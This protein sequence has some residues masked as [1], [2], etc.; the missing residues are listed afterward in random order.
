MDAP[1]FPRT[2]RLLWIAAGA[3]TVM[4]LAISVRV[5]LKPE[6]QSVY[7]VDYAPAGH[8]WLHGGEVY[9]AS[10]HFVY[11]PLTAAAFVPFSVLPMRVGN[12]VWRWFYVG[13][14]AWVAVGWLGGTRWAAGVFLLML[15]LCVGN[16]NNGQINMLVFVLVAGGVWSARE[17]RWNLAALL[18]AAAGFVKIYPLAVGL[19]LAV[20]FPRQLGWRLLVALAGLFVLSLVVQR[21]SYAWGEYGSWFTVLGGDNRLETDLY[22]TWRDFGFLLR[23]SGVPLSDRA[24][25]VMEA[26]AGGLLALFLLIG[27]RWRGWGREPLLT[28]ALYLGCA[29]M[30][31]FGPATEAATYVLLAL[32][33]CAA[34]ATA[35]TAG[36]TRRWPLAAA[37]VLLLVT[38]GTESWFHSHTHHLYTRAQ[39]P[40]AA[41]VFAGTVA[42]WLWSQRPV[43]PD[44]ILSP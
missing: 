3:W 30:L 18:L 11:S 20:L 9:R 14:F 16:V 40:V 26:A 39:Q 15:P 29:W 23:A 8:Q 27:Q 42:A 10:R 22:A 43:R 33:L 6:H 36:Q 41:L 28:G 44:T 32:P 25:R 7:T 38:D 17:E 5:A 19:L 21:P 34:L 35:W 37:Y 2:R 12:V 31:L 24:Y 13:A 1:I 4:L